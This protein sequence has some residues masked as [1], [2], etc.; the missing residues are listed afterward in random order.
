MTASTD[1]SPVSLDLSR[2]E[3][4]IVHHVMLDSIGLGP[5]DDDLTDPPACVLAVI[6]K[7]ESDDHEF[8]P[9]ELDHIGYA[10]GA[11]ARREGTPEVDRELAATIVARVDEALE[12]TTAPV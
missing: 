8:T 9:L 1:V 3:Q 7:L 10:C 2:P 12:G 11:Y 4:W 5:G 6:G